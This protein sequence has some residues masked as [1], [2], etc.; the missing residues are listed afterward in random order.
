MLERDKGAFMD[1]TLLKQIHV[2]CVI[3]TISL[4]VFRGVGLILHAAY[5]KQ[6]WLKIVP[7]VNDTVLLLSA[8]ALAVSIQQYPLVHHWLTIK[9]VALLIYIGIGFYLFKGAHTQTK[10]IM[11][12]LIACA[13]FSLM[14][15][16]AINK[17]SF[18]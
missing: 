16:T 8:V 10:R 6:R 12:L 14:V 13:V 4:F 1:Y 11:S 3:I 18:I 5:M 15:Y 17:T 7:H 9:L 2:T